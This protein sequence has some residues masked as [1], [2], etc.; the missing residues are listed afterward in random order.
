MI[1]FNIQLISV[2]YKNKN[3]SNF[4]TS[5]NK[6][7]KMSISVIAITIL[8]IVCTLPTAS[9]SFVYEKLYSTDYGQLCILLCNILT[10]TYQASNLIILYLT[11]KQFSV[12]LKSIIYR[13]KVKDSSTK[14]S[15]LNTIQ[16]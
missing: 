4:T 16:H 5:K 1:I 7:I 15:I 8:F 13:N 3:H 12:E 2:V 9:I 11:N 14:T 6:E 10:Y